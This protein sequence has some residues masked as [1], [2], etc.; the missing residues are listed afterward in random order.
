MFFFTKVLFKCYSFVTYRLLEP[1]N[2]ESGLELFLRAKEHPNQSRSLNLFQGG[3]PDWGDFIEL[4]TASSSAKTFILTTYIIQCALPKQFQQIQLPGENLH[5][6]L[7]NTDNKFD[8]LKLTEMIAKYL[9]KTPGVKSNIGKIIRCCLKNISLLNCY[10]NNQYLMTLYNLENFI[11][12]EESNVVIIDSICPYY[13]AYHLDHPSASFVFYYNN[14]MTILKEAT[15]FKNVVHFYFKGVHKIPS[16]KLCPF[17][18]YILN[19]EKDGDLFIVSVISMK[20]N[21]LSFKYSVSFGFDFNVIRDINKH[22]DC[23]Q[24]VYTTYQST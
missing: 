4:N 8:L 20:P 2:I 19:V 16:E 18:R 5:V 11:K 6:T 15:K 22:E 14:I 10:D 9:K 24:N 21:V 17:V 7:I 1:M 3:G 12:V 13:W 23:E